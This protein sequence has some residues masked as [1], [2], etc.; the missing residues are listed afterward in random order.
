MLHSELPETV[1]TPV[2]TRPRWQ[3]T[4][5]RVTQIG[6][7]VLAAVL[8]SQQLPWP[9]TQVMFGIVIAQ[10]VLAAIWLVLGPG[11]V[12]GRVLL[13]PLW[14]FAAALLGG[15]FT[16]PEDA[17]GII[18]GCCL[19]TSLSVLLVVVTARLLLRVRLV[20]M[21]GSSTSA[22]FQYRVRHLLILMLIT[23]LVMAVVRL[24]DFSPLRPPMLREVTF[25]ASGF[26]WALGI[27]PMIFVTLAA[28]HT[29][30]L[31]AGLTAATGF[32]VVTALASVW[33]AAQ[34]PSRHDWSVVVALTV[35]G[36]VGYLGTLLGLLL[37][38]R[39]GYRLMR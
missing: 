6:L 38:R 34:S 32:A 8:P 5:Y 24:V 16:R 11:N 39:E 19:V 1:S 36:T 15:V 22:P 18:L 10:C 35:V 30:S 14:I 33:F 27:L 23:S 3:W 21:N 2:A 31:Y 17:F 4:R 26:V 20:N 29:A 12:W 25:L 28:R 7:L 13:A 9:T 37:R